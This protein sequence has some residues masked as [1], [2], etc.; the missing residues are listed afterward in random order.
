MSRTSCERSDLISPSR[1]K[2]VWLIGHADFCQTLLCLWDSFGFSQ[3]TECCGE[4]P[5]DGGCVEQPGQCSSSRESPWG[6]AWMVSYLTWLEGSS[7]IYSNFSK[8]KKRFIA[9]FE[10]LR[11]CL[12]IWNQRQMN[13]PFFFFFLPKSW[14]PGQCLSSRE[15]PLSMS[16]DGELLTWSEGSS[17]VLSKFPKFKE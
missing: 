4:W 16:S 17:R 5:I 13:R 1:G 2:L 12:Q 10:V 9:T 6:R 7:R 15:P 3:H 14:R 8:F 11:Q